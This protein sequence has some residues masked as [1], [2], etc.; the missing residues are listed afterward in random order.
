MNYKLF[1]SKGKMVCTYIVCKTCVQRH[2]LQL[3][4]KALVE[5]DKSLKD[6]KMN[7]KYKKNVFFIKK[8]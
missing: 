1:L 2:I 5:K 4:S 8:D 6:N 3:T 7:E